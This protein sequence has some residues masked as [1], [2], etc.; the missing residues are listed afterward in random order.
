LG[1]KIY[2]PGWGV[3]KIKKKR[4]FGVGFSET[5]FFQQT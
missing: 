5:D 3:L 4:R 2:G 1:K